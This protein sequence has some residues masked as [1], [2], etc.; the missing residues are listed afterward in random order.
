MTATA[1]SPTPAELARS[2]FEQMWN[3]RDRGLLARL[4]APGCTGWAEGGQILGREAWILGAFE[5]FLGAFP[6][7]ALVVDG[8]VAEGNEVVV[9]WRATGTHSGSA[10][11]VPASGR[12]VAFRGMSWLKFQNGQ[13]IEGVDSWNQSALLQTLTQGRAVDSVQL[14]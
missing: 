4:M 9:R 8:T 10:L 7:L 2:W 1:A 3:R 14:L 11:G 6:D 12:K 5:T 13:I